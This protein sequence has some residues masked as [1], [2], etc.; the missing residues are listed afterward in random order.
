MQ[1]GHIKSELCLFIRPFERRDRT[2]YVTGSGA[3]PPVNFFVSG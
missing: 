1:K 2:Y 3:R